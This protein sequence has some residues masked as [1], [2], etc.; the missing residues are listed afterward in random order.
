VPACPTC[1]ASSPPDARYC[2]ACGSRLAD[3]VPPERRKLATVLFCDLTGSTAL[4][5][6]LDA[7]SVR[8]LSLRYF[9]AMRAVIERHGGSVEKF[10]GD[11]VVALFGVPVAH[12]DDALR[13]I[14]AALEM[15]ERMAALSAELEPVLGSPLQIHVG[16]YTGEV[17]TGPASGAE[18]RASGDVMNVAARLEEAAAPG[19]ILIGDRTR[20]LARDHVSV[21]PVGPLALKGKS[22][23]VPAYRVRSLLAL[24]PDGRRLRARLVGRQRDL[25]V[26]EA[27]LADCQATRRARVVAVTGEPGAGKSRIAR[28]FLGASAGGALVLRGRCPSYGEG[29]TYW[30]LAQ[31]LRAAAGIQADD[32]AERARTRLDRLVARETGDAATAELLAAAAGLSAAPASPD[33]IAWAARELL[34]A[35]AREEPVV[36]VLD[37]LQWAE[38]TFL[39][40]VDVL[41][42][43]PAP[44]LLLCLARSEIAEHP[45][46]SGSRGE[47]AVVA[48]GP[49]ADGDAASL[50]DD[51]LGRGLDRRLRARL[52]E[53]AGGNPLFLEELCEMLIDTGLVRR[54]E[55]GWVPSGEM[56]EIPLPLTLD[57]LLASRVDLLGAHERAVIECA[58]VEG[59]AFTRDAVLT[60]SPPAAREGVD[61]ALQALVER[62]L[63]RATSAGGLPGYRFHHQLIDR[64]S[65]V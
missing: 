15:Q 63:V 37:D 38:P 1:G 35:L 46:W 4:G 6:R 43:A 62:D 5:E 57:A 59:R 53:T 18:P 39:R 25:Q 7:E 51:A 58:A 45:D 13:A 36:L 24:P 44:L 31:A 27:A 3:G 26:L 55:G 17:V 14:R 11:A 61:G 33:D 64:K 54:V 10:I 48:L 30:P 21:E 8:A 40:L 65:V 2:V 41:A 47:R 32:P 49:L 16:I 52:I 34:V 42:T 56:P 50:V 12:E 60:L 22:G 28:E 29:I 19:E 23:R 9:E 20:L